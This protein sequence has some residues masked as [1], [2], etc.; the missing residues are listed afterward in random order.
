MSFRRYEI[1]LPTRYNDGP[2]VEEEQFARTRRERVAEFGAI[3]WHPDRLQGLW[4]HEGKVFEDANIKVVIDVDDTPA[5][6]RFFEEFK[7]TKFSWIAVQMNADRKAGN[8]FTQMRRLPGLPGTVGK[9]I[10]HP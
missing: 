7:D 9:R 5:A 6:Q 10:L 1:L 3:T 8:R 2:P 4:T